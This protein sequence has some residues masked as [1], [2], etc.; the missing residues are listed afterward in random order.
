MQENCEEQ[1]I[2]KR[3]KSIQ[4]KKLTWPNTDKKIHITR[5]KP[6]EGSNTSVCLLCNLHKEPNFSLWLTEFLENNNISMRPYTG[7]DSK[8]LRIELLENILE[9]AFDKD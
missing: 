1:S 5:C 9:T 2:E 4:N 6:I 7:N 3:I 8:D